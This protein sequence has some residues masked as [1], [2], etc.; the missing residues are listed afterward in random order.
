MNE[1]LT[2]ELT[3]EELALISGGGESDQ[4]GFGLR[5]IYDY[6]DRQNWSMDVYD[7]NGDGDGWDEISYT[8]QVLAGAT[9]AVGLNLIRTGL[10]QYAGPVGIAAAALGLVALGA[11]GIDTYRYGPNIQEP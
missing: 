7:R 6:W 2:R 10:P 11:H 5:E 4:N 9:G 8:Y 1:L 3:N